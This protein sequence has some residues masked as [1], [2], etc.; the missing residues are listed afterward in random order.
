LLLGLDFF[1]FF[2]LLLV[3][4]FFTLLRTLPEV[5]GDLIFFLDFLI[6]LDFS[7]DLFISEYS[8]LKHFAFRNFWRLLNSFFYTNFIGIF[9]TFQCSR[10]ISSFWHFII[11]KDKNNIKLKLINT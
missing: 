8:F 11:V 10:S 4:L 9:I 7:I 5:V 6:F 2:V 1:I 3:I